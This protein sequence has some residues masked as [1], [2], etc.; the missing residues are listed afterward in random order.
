MRRLCAAR[1]SSALSSERRA[2]G[3]AAIT[4]PVGSTTWARSPICP[5]G[6]AGVRSRAA[7]SPLCAAAATS[8]ARSASASS[9]PWSIPALVC[10]NRKAHTMASTT[11][12][13]PV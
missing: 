1:S 13:A 8:C 3:V 9:M 5:A 11:A 10:R 7:A 12:M 2:E 4:R 6:S